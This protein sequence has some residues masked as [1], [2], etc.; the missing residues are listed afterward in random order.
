MGLHHTSGADPAGPLV[1]EVAETSPPAAAPVS[2]VSWMTEMPVLQGASVTLRELR[3]SDAPTLLAMLGSGEAAR[4]VST[5]PGCLE[6]V[7]RFIAWTAGEREQGNH[8]CFGIVPHGETNAVGIIQF[9][10]SERHFRTAEWGF[11]LGP[12]Y[13]G[14]GLF[15]EAAQLALDFA[16]DV[17]RINRIEARVAVRNGR[18]NGALR[19]LGAVQEGILRRSFLKDG[20]YLDQVMWAILASDRARVKAP[21]ARV[22]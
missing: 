6:A 21:A 13:W 16:F 2:S 19:K 11:G 1:S 15:T 4:F 18:G 8:A 12:A 10:L 3:P 20:E 7:E 5:P 14:R 22:H 17:V 9:I